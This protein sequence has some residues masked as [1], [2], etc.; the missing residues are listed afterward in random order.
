MASEQHDLRGWAALASL[1]AVVSQPIL[2]IDLETRVGALEARLQSLTR[3]VQAMEAVLKQGAGQASISAAPKGEPV[4][5]LSD[6]VGASPFRVL[7]KTLDRSSGRVDL[8]LDVVSAP[9]DKGLWQSVQ[10]GAPVP[11]A[12][13]LDPQQA[14]PSQLLRLHLERATNFE[15]GSRIHVSARIDPGQARLVRQIRVE[16]VE[17]TGTESEQARP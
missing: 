4:W 15:P 13:T 12:L 8:L 7:H 5:V 9:P 11:L 14:D 10:R 16:H 6:Y 2:A 17:A 3:R 1:L